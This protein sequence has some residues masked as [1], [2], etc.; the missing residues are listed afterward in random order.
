MVWA[1]TQYATRFLFGLLVTRT[2]R[3]DIA[4]SYTSKTPQKGVNKHFKPNSQ[5]T[6][7]K[8]TDFN[9]ILRNDKDHGGR[10]VVQT[11]DWPRGQTFGF[12]LELLA[13]AGRLWTEEELFEFRK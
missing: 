11:P 5:N 4:P 8:Y 10:T 7:N 13:S 3:T 12:G 2:S 6:K 9:Q 1:N